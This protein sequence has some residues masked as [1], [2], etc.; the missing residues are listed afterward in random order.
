MASVAVC[1]TGCHQTPSG[2][3]LDRQIIGEVMM[4]S[5]LPV[6]LRAICTP[7]GRLSGTPNAH[8]AE[9]YVADKLREYG[10]KNVHLEPFT[11][12]SW[13][14]RETV[15]TVLGESP[16]VLDG[17]VSLGNCLS[18]PPEGITAEL[19]DVG[20]GA[21]EELEAAGDKLA[22]RFG[23]AREGGPHRGAKMSMALRRGAA[24][25][26]Q[27]SHLEDRA[28]V[29]QCHPE[30]R[31]EP[32]IVVTGA[33]GAELAEMLKAGEPV[34]LNIKIVADS[35]EAT[36]NNVVGEIPGSG[37]LAG[38]VVILGAHLDSW[39]LAEGAI[40]NGNGSTAIL[41]AARALA[42]VG[43]RPKRTVRFVWFMGEEHGLHGSKAYV[44]AHEHE[45]D[46][47][48]VMVNADMPGSPRQ[49]A[50]FGHEEMI[51]FLE[52]VSADL[53]GFEMNE[54]IDI[55]SWEASDHGPF[56]KQGVCALT[57]GGELGPG[58]KFYHS[59]GDTFE[60]VD[61][62]GTTQAAA[63]L[64]VLVRRLADDP[65]LPA[66]RLAP[67]EEEEEEEG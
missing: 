16:R 2:D 53:A 60:T 29:G 48:A 7:G 45:L 55:A 14:D 21:E 58:V 65:N 26:V 42:A 51:G 39:H 1:V 49:L 32:G 62:R 9:A 56:M 6:N 43:W 54:K 25:L 47:V 64:A 50:T 31:P 10:L 52:R 61:T 24:G 20:Q 33:E 66:V 34:R 46:N 17:A 44:A 13:Q 40:D 5:E 23:L 11:M 37:P 22:G 35:W 15:V 57:M 41:E 4:N 12:M 18:T 59:T 67:E 38:E 8:R 63:V 27:V 36:P 19:I 28:R 30:P 3:V